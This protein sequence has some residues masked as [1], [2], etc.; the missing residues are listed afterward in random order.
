MRGF[1]HRERANVCFFIS[2]RLKI[3]FW[4]KLGFSPI[5]FLIQI[6]EFT[7][8]NNFFNKFTF[9]LKKDF[10]GWKIYFKFW[11]GLTLVDLNEIYLT[12][13]PEF[14]ISH[15]VE[16]W[17]KKLSK[18]QHATNSIVSKLRKVSIPNFDRTILRLESRF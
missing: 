16:S 6:F 3:P 12:K 4:K 10:C 11:I 18:F 7:H 14:E 8:G 15:S 17:G 13:P 2:I 1:L 9:H 5:Y